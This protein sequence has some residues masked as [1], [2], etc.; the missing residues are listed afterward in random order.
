MRPL[1]ALEL[2]LLASLW[3]GSF[4]CMKVAAPEFGPVP[5]IELRV[6]LAALLLLPVLKARVGFH[7]LRRHWPLILLVGVINTAL[8]FSLL[9]F[10]TLYLSAGLTSILNSTAPLWAALVASI[11]L[12][13]RLTFGRVLGLMVGFLG[14]VVLFWGRVEIRGGSM[15]VPAAAALTAT[16]GY[17]FSANF[18]KKKLSGI[19]SITL[20]AGTM[21]GAALFLFVPAIVLRPE[22]APSPTAWAAVL[23]LAA[24]STAVA[25]LLYFHL[26]S[27][28]GPTKAIAVAYLIPVFGMFWGAVILGEEITWR[29]A[30]GCGVILAGT[31]LAAGVIRTAGRRSG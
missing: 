27:N 7:E 1:D 10:V 6:A 17:G 30:L 18:V 20:A 8:P 9:A 12:K 2:V 22:T 29:M 11:W 16:L 4:L 24:A 5:L 3:G 15:M 28:V 23:V 14:V 26:L 31:T 13:D 21:C 25:Y 19:H